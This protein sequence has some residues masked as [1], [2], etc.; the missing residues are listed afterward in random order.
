MLA[1]L[2]PGGDWLAAR[3][4]AAAGSPAGRF[5]RRYRERL[6]AVC[7]TMPGAA[8]LTF[9]IEAI[10]ITPT[11]NPALGPALAAALAG[12]LTISPRLYLGTLFL[13]RVVK[14]AVTTVLAAI[15]AA[16]VAAVLFW[17]KLGP[18]PPWTLDETV[19][20]LRAGAPV[21]LSNL[22]A[23]WVMVCV[24]RFALAG[25]RPRPLGGAVLF[26]RKMAARHEAAHALVASVLGLPMEGAWVLRRPDARGIGG[27]VMLG[28]PTAAPTIDD[29]YGLL[30]RRVAVNV[31]GV[32]GARGTRPMDAIVHELEQQ[33]DWV[34][35]AVLSWTGAALRSDRVLVQDVLEAVVPALHTAP[36]KRAIA[37]AAKML[38]RAA[39]DPVS[40]EDIAAVAHRF[41]LALP[42]V[43]ALAGPPA[44][45]SRAPGRGGTA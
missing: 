14:S 18:A 5:V 42:A 29:L 11:T 27:T 45:S 17:D 3:V 2:I 36:W 34:Q 43:E 40:P 25:F 38:L 21:I 23:L 22:L 12:T 10:G 15:G 32:A 31:A 41:D 44:G 8:L 26:D 7:V 30:V 16:A 39:G 9:K 35:A 37:S 24:F 19:A 6:L 1:R 4:E 28:A 33:Q 20:H 13:A